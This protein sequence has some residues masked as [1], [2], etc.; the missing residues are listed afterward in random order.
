[1][2]TEYLLHDGI[3]TLGNVG[4]TLGLFI[5][6]SFT[7]AI[8][9]ILNL[10]VSK[11]N[12]QQVHNEGQIIHV[13][14]N[15]VDGLILKKGIKFYGFRWCASKKYFILVKEIIDKE[16]KMLKQEIEELKNHPEK[17]VL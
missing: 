2:H 7:G 11:L 16:T 5:G 17:L 14:E 10:L 4:G 15:L 13:Q 6:F 1:M 3:S 9:Y 8:S 12:T